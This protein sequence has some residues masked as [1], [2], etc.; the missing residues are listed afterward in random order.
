MGGSEEEKKKARRKKKE[1]AQKTFVR[2]LETKKERKERTQ[3][4]SL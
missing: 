1:N 3:Q 2:Q 4:I